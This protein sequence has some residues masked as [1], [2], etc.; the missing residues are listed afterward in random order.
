MK[1]YW[2]LLIFFLNGCNDTSNSKGANMT[3][4]HPI[5]EVALH[6]SI[7]ELLA[8]SPVEFISSCLKEV[9]MCWYEIER[10]AAEPNLPTILMKHGNTPLTL[11]QVT[12]ITIVVNDER[13]DEVHNLTLILRSIPS[14]SLHE[15][16][17]DFI[18]SLIE[19]IELAGWEYY[20]FPSDPRIPGTEANK[21]A[22]ADDVLGSYVMSHPW[23][24]PSHKIDLERWLKFG[25][26]YNWYFYND[27]AYL[28]L[29]AWRRDSD[30]APK[31][32]ATYLITLEFL[33]ETE[34]WLSG[35]TEKEDR[36]RWKELLPE[37]LEG[38][39]QQR[40]ELE[41]KARAA[42]IAIDENYQD[43]SIKALTK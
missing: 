1:P 21:I 33:T 17:R 20:Y 30:D 5:V 15:E 41:A 19:K 6:E 29:K 39:K 12:N 26:F 16:Y 43:P 14:N 2:I 3:N 35:F 23:L 4:E 11:E 10:R 27:G 34:Y 22:S 7:T 37:R 28:H 24:E 8:S 13:G 31:E 36:T 18:Y 25:S 42:G 40:K 9:G 38:Y 32:R